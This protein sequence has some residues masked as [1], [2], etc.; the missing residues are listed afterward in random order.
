MHFSRSTFFLF[1]LARLYFTVR[2]IA[3][4]ECNISL[5]TSV[6]LPVRAD[7]AVS[8]KL[9]SREWWTFERCFA[10]ANLRPD[11]GDAKISVPSCELFFALPVNSALNT[12]RGYTSEDTS[13]RLIKRTSIFAKIWSYKHVDNYRSQLIAK[14]SRV[15]KFLDE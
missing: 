3:S 15:H 5:N 9:K 8:G 1:S 2:S 6:K 14:Y 11:D 4:C 7:R 13:R 10:N 12:T